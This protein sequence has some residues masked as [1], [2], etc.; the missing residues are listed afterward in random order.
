MILATEFDGTLVRKNTSV[1]DQELIDYLKFH[2]K[3]G[4]ELTLLTTRTGQALQDAK[5]W[6]QRRGLAFDYINQ[7]PEWFIEAEGGDCRVIYYD[8]I[9]TRKRVLIERGT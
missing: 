3:A 4:W 8:K 2:K 6:C 9:L 7:N 1:G 5:D